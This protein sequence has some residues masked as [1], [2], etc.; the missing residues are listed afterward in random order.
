MSVLRSKETEFYRQLGVRIGIYLMMYG[1]GFTLTMIA[2]MLPRMIEEYALSLAHGGAFMTLMNTGGVLGLVLT[3]LFGDR[4]R[5][6]IL[7]FISYAMLFLGMFTTGSV[8]GYGPLLVLFFIM[9]MSSRAV[10]TMSNALIT[11]SH[12]INAGRYLNMLHMSISLGSLS[13]PVMLRILMDHNI[14]W[15]STFRFLG[16][17]CLIL[18][19]VGWK[20]IR[21]VAY[22]QR[23]RP[24]T[25]AGKPVWL[26][27]TVIIAGLLILFYTGH[28]IIL[29]VW[30][31]M[32]MEE[33]FALAPLTASLSTTL[34]WTGIALSRLIGSRVST[35]SNARLLIRWGALLGGLTLTVAVLSRFPTLTMA[36]FALTGLLSGATIPILIDLVTRACPD[37]ASQVTSTLYM[38]SIASSIAFPWLCGRVADS[39]GFRAGFLISAASLFSVMILT[40][41]LPDTARRD[42]QRE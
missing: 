30:S 13:G 16:G 32:F 1:F 21:G 3:W 27:P 26:N 40:F 20:L 34:F 12:P 6:N 14:S 36:G 33:V 17:F 4:I 18:F 37:R 29:N 2:P 22:M 25:E 28:Q 8:H 41:A 31:S 7:F 15:Q 5:K 11:E 39:L 9:G 10:D 42:D 19:L 23:E 24:K 35:H 38:F